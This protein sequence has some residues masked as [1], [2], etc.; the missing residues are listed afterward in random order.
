MDAAAALAHRR[1]DYGHA[2]W[3]CPAPR[4]VTFRCRFEVSCQVLNF[5]GPE[6]SIIGRQRVS[7]Q[8]MGGQDHYTVHGEPQEDDAE[9]GVDQAEEGRTNAVGDEA[10][11]YDQRSEVNIPRQSRGL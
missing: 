3:D 2:F 9:D 5:Y 7:V 1:R 8:E 11:D 10:N 4:I 6:V